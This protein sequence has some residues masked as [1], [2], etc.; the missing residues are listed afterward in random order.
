MK[1]TLLC[2]LGFSGLLRSQIVL[3][4]TDMP[5]VHDTLRISHAEPDQTLDFLST[6]ANYAW[7]FSGLQSTGQQLNTYKS[8][9][10]APLLIQFIYGSFALPAY[11][12]SYYQTATDLPVAELGSLLPVALEDINQFSRSTSDSL[13]L[14]GYSMVVSGQELPVKSDTIETKYRFPLHFED[15]FSSRGYTQLDMNPIYNAKWRQHRLRQTIADGW[16]QLITPY[17]SFDVLRIHHK[18]FETDSFYVVLNNL[19]FWIPIAVPEVNIYE[20]RAAGEGEPI[21]Q[22]STARLTDQEAITAISYRGSFPANCR[23]CGERP[24]STIVPKS[25]Q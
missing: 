3:H 12:T 24:G 1:H 5:A 2:I 14:V 9:A 8:L 20:W 22:I 18:I 7:D 6:G 23:T 25:C 17:G 10:G 13:T 16:G 15:S 4:S 19:G 11:Q 21:L